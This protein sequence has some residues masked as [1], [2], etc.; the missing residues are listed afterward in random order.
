ML[1]GLLGCSNFGSDHDLT[2]GEFKPHDE[3]CADSSE[4]GAC[5]RFCVCLSAL[6]M[7]ALCLSQ[8]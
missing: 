4:P 6:P 1:S 3:L 2:V 8:I 5:F 7:L